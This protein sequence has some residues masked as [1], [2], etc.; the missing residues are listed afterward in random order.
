MDVHC[1]A[2]SRSPRQEISLPPGRN[3]TCV[4]VVGSVLL[5][6]D[7]SGEV[8]VFRFEGLRVVE[9]LLPSF[10]LGLPV[11]SVSA[12]AGA[13]DVAVAVT[14]SAAFP[15]ELGPRFP[16]RLRP[17]VW[18]LEGGARVGAPGPEPAS[19]LV[20]D[21]EGGVTRLAR[22]VGVVERW[23]PAG[24]SPVLSL[25]PFRLPRLGHPAVAVGHT[26]GAV[27]IAREVPG[28]G[29][30]VLGVYPSLFRGPI[31]VF[32]APDDPCSVLAIDSQTSTRLHP[33]D[34]LD[35]VSWAQRP[36]TPHHKPMKVHSI[37]QSGPKL[38]V[39]A[40]GTG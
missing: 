20:G 21:S 14:A 10:A 12:F 30:V 34:P 8:H 31:F 40:T 25:A 9:Q 35:L 5:V 7:G 39:W 15:L 23:C 37:S 36:G 13:V 3:V 29:F 4:A 17:V 22:G 28:L 16:L 38:L 6:G 18:A 2:A 1:G 32:P 24:M 27:H 26:C 11:L 19:A 33:D